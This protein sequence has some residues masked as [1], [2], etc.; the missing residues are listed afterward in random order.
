MTRGLLC[1]QSLPSNDYQSIL[2]V[3]HGRVQDWNVMER[4]W[5]RCIYQYMRCDPAEHAFLLVSA[6]LH[7]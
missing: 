2:P 4:A 3:Q 5:H 1:A 7:A 6:R